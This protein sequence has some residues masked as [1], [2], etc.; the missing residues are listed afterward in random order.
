[1]ASVWS[2]QPWTTLARGSDNDYI[3]VQRNGPCP[4]ACNCCVGRGKCKQNDTNA[5]A[6]DFLIPIMR[7]QDGELKEKLIES[8]K[9][10]ILHSPT[11]TITTTITSATIINSNNKTANQVKLQ[12]VALCADLCNQSGLDSV[13][14]AKTVS[15]T[16]IIQLILKLR[17]R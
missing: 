10:S 1:M 12:K 8:R 13:L 6:T 17:L 3:S 16:D 2:P 5:C 7:R 15:V 14:T 9:D 11:T 4:H